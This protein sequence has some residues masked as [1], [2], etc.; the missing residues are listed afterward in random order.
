M[1]PSLPV[2]DLLSGRYRLQRL[3]GQGGMAD[4]YRAGDETG[5]A[6]VALKLVR[7]TDP[8]L[9]R[10]LT[11]EAKAV[12]GFDHPGL[13]RL[14]DAGV[15]QGQP[16]L[17]ME[18]V[19]GPTLG[20]R[21]RQGPLPPDRCAALGTSL[22]GALAYVHRHGIVHRDVKPGNVLL[23][24]GPRV[25]LADFGIAQ[26]VDASSM[27]LTGTTLGTAAYMAPE[28][29]EHH[30]VGPAADVWSL[31]AILL[32]ALS[33][34]R[35]FEGSPAEVVARR[36]AGVVPPSDDL[37]VPWRI[38]LVSMM[39]HDPTLRPAAAEVADMLHSPA[40]ARPWDP[41]AT[42]L[43]PPVEAGA[44]AA[45]T[46]VEGVA[47]TM[48][49]SAGNAT[50]VGAAPVPPPPSSPRRHL[51]PLA[52]AAAAAL[53][54]LVVLAAWAL[55]PTPAP[56]S[57]RGSTTTT[58][59]TSTTTTTAVTA[60]T[61]S[62]ALVRDVQQGEAAGTLSS[63]V[64][65]TILDQLGQALGAAASGDST[66]T[67]NALGQIDATIGNAAQSGKATQAEA[68]TLFNDVSALAAV[69]DV[70]APTTTSPPPGNTAPPSHHK[71]G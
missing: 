58:T 37:P 30:R 19:E 38:L 10:R 66:Q 39:E 3:I 49:E 70:A 28:Q 42:A 65:K 41:A 5:G 8:E 14:L 60:S 13:V 9:A 63:D 29:I 69:L 35:G 57:H 59:S 36:M 21:L 4:V 46:V 24:P 7:S 32:E 17:V 43:V 51:L 11:Q 67:A 48:V 26:L 33:G 34:R 15:H 2:T 1:T 55:S 64:G 18:L 31:G 53:A 50:L 22:A 27:T 40:F 45:P 62:A 71:K 23:G 20:T 52:L 47:P 16:F 6:D 56:T 44:G 68:T 54:L 61:A 12:S 25:R